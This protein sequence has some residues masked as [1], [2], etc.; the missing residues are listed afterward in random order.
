MNEQATALHRKRGA[1]RRLTLLGLTGLVIVVLASG[2]IWSTFSHGASSGSV[3][4]H[5][6]PAGNVTEFAVPTS[7]SELDEVAAGPDGNLWFTEYNG[8]KIGRI[9]TSGSIIEFAV[10]TSAS[11][12]VGI[13]AGPDGNLWFTEYNGN[14]IGRITSGK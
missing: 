5:T 14:K 9:S 12:P 11:G 6:T 13:T 4:H 7:A 2:L 1:S 3:V 10:P 8:N